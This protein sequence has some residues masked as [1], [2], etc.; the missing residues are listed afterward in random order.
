MATT[1]QAVTFKVRGMDCASCAQTVETGVEKLT[2][3]ERCQVNFTTETLSV[4]GAV[5]PEAVARR[6]RELG[7]E[8]LEPEAAEAGAATAAG[9]HPSL[10]RYMLG[11]RDGLLTLIALLLILPGL[12]FNELLPMLGLESVLLHV[13]SLAALVVAGIPV[14]RSA[15]RALAINREININVLMTIASIG[16]VIIGAYTEAGLVMVLFALGETLEGYT[17]DRARRSIRSLMSVAPQEA[18]VLRPCIDCASH[19]G[20]DGYSG[21]PC[22]FCGLE[23]KRVPVGELQPGE[24]I[25]VRPGER[26]PMDGEVI[27]GVSAVNQAPITG[28]SLPVVRAEGNQVFASSIN[29]EGV[30]HIRITHRVEDNTISRVIQMVEEAQ[31]QRAPTQRFIDRFARIYTPAVVVL[32][33]LIAVLPPL[34][35]GAPFMPTETEQGWLYRALAL[36]VVA[37][38]CALVISTPVSLISAISNAAHRGVLFKGGASMEAL[39]RVQA[40]AFDKTGT[41]TRGEPVVVAVQAADCT[42][43]TN[44]G[45][46]SCD[47]VL[48]LASAVERHSEHPL[49]RAVLEASAERGVARRYGPAEAVTAL[50][51]RGVTGRV[52]ERE[53]LVG[54]HRYFDQHVLH[55]STQCREISEATTE[56]H[57]TILVAGDGEYLGYLTVADTARASSRRALEHLRREG[58]SPLVMLTG[59]DA[60]SAE[61]IAREVGLTDVRAGLLPEEKVAAVR[62]LR[63]RH[64]GVAMVGDGINDAPAL[65]TA[66]VGIAM[67][68]AGTAQALETADIALMSDDLGQLPFARGLAQAAMRTI[69]TN[70]VLSLAIKA[71]FL[72]L[73]LWGMGTIWMAVVADM[74]AS[75]L[76]TVNG[77]RLLR[78]RERREWAETERPEQLDNI[79]SKR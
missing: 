2:G 65:A 69:K 29:G 32:A 14:A 79:G 72:L 61:A 28:E 56:G 57:S 50:S 73:V 45:C 18:T 16:A 19:L 34:L 11:R 60:A 3:V 36:L 47:E 44:S 21:G 55:T 5:S 41:L 58:L 31:A 20:R 53:I 40:M 59:D 13:L 27:A 24:T 43:P 46:A 30:L 49:A 71:A 10:L 70:I 42:L 12:V 15:G 52:E 68:A 78:W 63:E 39:A 66:N 8:P 77:T 48:A 33:A 64:G 9:D 54:S 17:A 38:P 35:F 23:E 26:I 76:V 75:L 4:H 7:Y 1:E 6:V 25:I 22:P 62:A 74:G 67:G 37:C 51:G